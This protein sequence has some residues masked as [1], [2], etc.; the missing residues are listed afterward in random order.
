M[1]D[2]LPPPPCH[3]CVPQL[4]KERAEVQRLLE[5]YY[6]LDYEDYVGG[7]KT[8]FRYA[9]RCCGGAVLRGAV[10]CCGCPCGVEVGTQ[11]LE[12]VQSHSRGRERGRGGSLSCILVP[13]PCILHQ[14]QMGAL[15]NPTP[16]LSALCC[17]SGN[18]MCRQAGMRGS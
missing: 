2:D 3:L 15:L 4:A 10:L 18:Q 6:K 16:C 5:E 1:D 8:R 14:R 12:D 7:V 17:L 9:P 13:H 11:P